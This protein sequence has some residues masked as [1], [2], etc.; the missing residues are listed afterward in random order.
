MLHQIDATNQSLGRLASRIAVI[1]RGK[2]SPKYRPNELPDDKV[3]VSNIDKIKYTGKKLEQKKY[4]HYSGY[5][6]GMKTRKLKDVIASNPKKV[7]NSAVYKMLAPN[8]LRSKIMK[9][10]EIK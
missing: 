2:T 8:R 1:L 9:N 4:Y 3:I 6:G 7:L 10:L 5:P